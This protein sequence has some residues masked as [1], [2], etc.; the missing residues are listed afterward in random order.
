MIYNKRG[1]TFLG[2]LL[3]VLLTVALFLINKYIYTVIALPL[4]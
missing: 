3:G 2:F 4:C 1:G